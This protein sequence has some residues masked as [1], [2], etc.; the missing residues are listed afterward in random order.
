MSNP[1][2][3]Y[4]QT[5][6]LKP[7]A[8]LLASGSAHHND[9]E[10]GWWRIIPRYVRDRTDSNRHLFYLDLSWVNSTRTPYRCSSQAHS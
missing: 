5:A 6:S 9:A 2:Q 3:R 7:A 1:A 4:N 10:R 8:W